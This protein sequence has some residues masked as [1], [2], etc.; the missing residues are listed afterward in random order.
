MWHLACHILGRKTGP[1]WAVEKNLDSFRSGLSRWRELETPMTQFLV[2]RVGRGPDLST[3]P[4]LPLQPQVVSSIQ[5]LPSA[6]A[7]LWFHDPFGFD[8][9]PDAYSA[10]TL[11]IASRS[12]KPGLRGYSYACNRN[13]VRALEQAKCEVQVIPTQSPLLKR[14]RLEFLFL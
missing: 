2:S 9:N 1:Y 11:A 7:D 8:V 10:E 5:D 14:E 6:V 12:W 4:F 13:F 3:R